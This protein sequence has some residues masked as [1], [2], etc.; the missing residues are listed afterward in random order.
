MSNTPPE[1]P[2]DIEAENEQFNVPR[3]D[4]P[5]ETEPNEAGEE[6]PTTDGP[7]PGVA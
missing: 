5:L 4:T 3:E 6:Q 1:S 2:E 7:T